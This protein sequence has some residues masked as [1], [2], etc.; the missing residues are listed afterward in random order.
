MLWRKFRLDWRYALGE[1]LIVVLGVLAALWVE[2]W[3]SERK[4]QLLERQ[5]MQSLLG[6]LRS[7]IESIDIA[8]NRTDVYA[9]GVQIVL[10][11]VERQ[12]VDVVPEDFARA[13]AFLS[14]LTFPVQSHATIN[15]LMSTGNLR[16]IRSDEVRSGIAEYY[17]AVEMQSQW[18][19]LWRN[20]QAEM[21]KLLA[22][23]I[24]VRIRAA[25]DTD[26]GK[27]DWW[28]SDEP[29]TDADVEQILQRLV[30]SPDAVPAIENMY[31][32]QALNYA[33]S[34]RLKDQ[35]KEIMQIVENYIQQF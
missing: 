17:S 21:G 26:Y 32:V 30:E 14:R 35:A 18:Q 20:H 6:D 13:V 28:I 34:T 19:P 7:D 25:V 33:Y 1:F 12:S 5:Y 4:D 31:R 27:P 10:S 9:T 11:S 22:R 2:N 23:F 8:L 16:I 24:G 3:N 29:V 15:D